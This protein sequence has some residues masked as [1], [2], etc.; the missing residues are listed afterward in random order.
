MGFSL[1]R[2]N[3][4]VALDQFGHYSAQRFYAQTEWGHIEQ[5]HI[6]D[7][8]GENARL[9]RGADRH[10][11]IRVNGLVRLFAASQ[12]LDQGLDGRHAS[13]APY[14]NHFVQI[15]L[16]DFCIGDWLLNGIQATLDQISGQL[17][18]LGARQLHQQMLW[19][20]SIGSDE[21]QINISLDRRRKFDLCF[22][23][24][25]SETLQ[26][27]AI[28][29]QIDSLITLELFNQPVDYSLIKVVA[30]QVRIPGRAF[31]F[32]DPV[33]YFKNGNVKGSPT[34]VENQNR[35]VLFLIQSISQRGR[36]RLVNNAQHIKTGNLPRVF[37]CLTLCIIE[38]SRHRDNRVLHLF[39]QIATGVVREL[40]QNEGRDLFRRIELAVDID[41]HS[42]VGSGHDLVW[43]L[44]DFLRHLGIF[45]AHETLDRKNRVL[46][47]QRSLSLCYLPDQSF[48][49]PGKRHDGRCNA[50][51]LA[52]NDHGWAIAFHG[53]YG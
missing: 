24:S 11:L 42:V 30:S 31:H 35:L 20:R 44:F 8:A 52:V 32:K 22:L 5:Q 40:A 3:R 27:L 12:T 46:R 17:L 41:A 19:S 47:I 16:A 48:T 53:R 13:R 15:L 50:S 14:Q 43:H 29:A 26:G 34:K 7:F 6:L 33:A 23:G 21:R 18:E 36:S 1:S 25:F 39:A 2:R 38:V 28:L 9:N 4:G 37:R 45:A 51:A 49:R 10:H